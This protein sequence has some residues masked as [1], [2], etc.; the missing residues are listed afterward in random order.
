MLISDDNI[1]QIIS[2]YQ[3]A[4]CNWLS[5]PMANLNLFVGLLSETSG[6]VCDGCGIKENCTPVTFSKVSISDISTTLQSIPH[7]KTNAELAQEL[8]I[9]KRQVAKRRKRGEL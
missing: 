6:Q 2:N 5:G 4:N 1:R 9:S 8:G 3:E 7:T